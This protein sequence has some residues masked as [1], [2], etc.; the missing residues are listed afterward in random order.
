MP[1]KRKTE[2]KITNNHDDELKTLASPAIVS[3]KR[4]L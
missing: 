1:G 4:R 2:R 3:A